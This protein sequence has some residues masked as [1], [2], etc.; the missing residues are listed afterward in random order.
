M[1]V[2]LVGLERR[3]G[4]TL[5]QEESEA[6]SISRRIVNDAIGFAFRMKLAQAQ[7]DVRGL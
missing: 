3:L 7:E 2:E 1:F 5:V 6:R 4:K